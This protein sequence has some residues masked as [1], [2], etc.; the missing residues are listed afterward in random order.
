M[1]PDEWRKLR[2]LTIDATKYARPRDLPLETFAG[3]ELLQDWVVG[4]LGYLA[5]EIPIPDPKGRRA[6]G[7]ALI[8]EIKAAIL[9]GHFVA[10][11]D[12]LIAGHLLWLAG[13]ICA[14]TP[15]A[16]DQI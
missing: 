7:Y 8:C 6:S 3:L 14:A 12:L 4:T 10:E 1:S 5:Q 16:C 2:D 11:R 13:E 15:L 9:V